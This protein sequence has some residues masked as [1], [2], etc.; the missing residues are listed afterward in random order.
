MH[1][2]TLSHKRHF[3]TRY[4]IAVI[5][6]ALAVIF[7]LGSVLTWQFAKR[8]H[9]RALLQWQQQLGMV[10]E[11]RT[12]AV[13]VWLE[14]QF[15]TLSGLAG[16]MSLQLY[17]TEY[18]QNAKG[19]EGVTDA[20]AQT[21]Y[22]SMLL[23]VTAERSGFD[24]SAHNALP[25]LPPPVKGGIAVLDKNG[26]QIAATR[27][28]PA[29]TGVLADFVRN[30][31]AAHSEFH[32]VFMSENNEPMMAFLVPVFAV[33][34]ESTASDQMGFVLGVRPFDAAV[35]GLLEQKGLTYTSGETLLL[36]QQEHMVEYLSPTTSPTGNNGVLGLR[37]DMDTPKLAETTAIRHPGQFIEA[38]DYHG[39]AVLATARALRLAPWVVMHKVD[40]KDAMHES[41]L[42]VRQVTGWL[43]FSM[44]GIMLLL[45]AVWRHAS[46]L[47]SESLAE[48]YRAISLKSQRQGELL[49]IITDSEPDGMFLMD[50]Q[51]VVRYLNARFAQT[52]G[53]APRDC[54]GRPLRA[55][56]DSERANRHLVIA[57]RVQKSEKNESI[58]FQQ[59]QAESVQ[60]IQANYL[61]M[62]HLP[63]PRTGEMVEGTLVIEQDITDAV[64]EHD[65][66]ERTLR[67]LVSTLVA[68]VDKRDSFA[69]N[70]SARVGTLAGKIADAMKLDATTRDT[71]IA[72]GNLMNVGKI[73]VPEAVLTHTGPLSTEQM[74]QV[75]RCILEGAALLEGIEFDGPVA[76]TI[77]QSQEHW[78]GTG[79]LGLKETA[80]L[81]PAR[82]VCVANVFIGMVSARAY[83]DR[84]TPEDILNQMLDQMGSRYDRAVVLALGHYIENTPEDESWMYQESNT[85][86]PVAKRK[87]A[88]GKKA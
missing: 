51:G 60:V 52:L 45:L 30:A 34:G 4:G 13:E 24:T 27:A 58:I 20:G 66:R 85:N 59:P 7:L 22:L 5:A 72:A 74:Q 35:L 18:T 77:R 56:L 12:A 8:E 28:M 21:T 15:N 11:I 73:F 46:S 71:A 3:T 50:T 25:Q 40:T 68:M 64:T 48:D 86:T 55:L 87:K 19:V 43:I 44:V 49:Q 41:S 39:R 78:D 79:M 75:R 69:A 2:P 17:M 42:R 33:Q 9:E 80:I 83:R 61:V 36:R 47:R 57:E 29:L 67:R 54:I 70:H 14:E 53:Q 37:L 63:D 6:A 10:A 82:I 26:T 1:I 16:N 62:R 32:D 31:R 81:L 76:E 38:M 65:R 23:Q 84:F 88:G